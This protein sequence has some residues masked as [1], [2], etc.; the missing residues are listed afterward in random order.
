MPA[1]DF[2]DIMALI[3]PFSLS[4]LSVILLT[5]A[6][7]I[8]LLSA[9][10]AVGADHCY[11][12]QYIASREVTRNSDTLVM[13]L[14]V[15]DVGGCI[16][17]CCDQRA[18]GNRASGGRFHANIHNHNFRRLRSHF[19]RP[20]YEQLRNFPMQRLHRLFTDERQKQ[21]EQL[22]IFHDSGDV[23]DN[24]ATPAD[25]QH[26][27]D[28]GNA[29]RRLI[30]AISHSHLPTRLRARRCGAGGQIHSRSAAP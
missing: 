19:V 1:L 6:P 16:K 21:C 9:Q 4:W 26:R 3:G 28:V 23:D 22:S 24:T 30:V 2:G 15:K 8:P 27:C 10:S 5:L 14:V 11:A 13:E 17:K 12:R 7:V 25:Q 29:C 20:H 18:K